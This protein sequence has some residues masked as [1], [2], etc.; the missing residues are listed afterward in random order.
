MALAQLQKS[1]R[2]IWTRIARIFTNLEYHFV[3]IRIIRVSIFNK[4]EK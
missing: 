2:N 4:V 3:K 1:V